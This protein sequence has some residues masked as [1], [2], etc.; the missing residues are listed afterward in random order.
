[1][2]TRIVGMMI[3][4]SL[5]AQAAEAGDHRGWGRG[6][7]DDDHH[8]HN[9][10]RQQRY[11]PARPY[12]YRQPASVVSLSFGSPYYAR[13]AYVMPQV[14]AYNQPPLTLPQAIVKTQDRYCREYQ[15]T[16]RVGN[17]PQ[18]GYGQACMQPDGSWQVVD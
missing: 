16:L 12:W 7:W 3:A 2:N 9:H 13:P 8:G 18:P 5:F 14:V 6:G 1:M 15:A 4:L 10:W 17:R 11:A